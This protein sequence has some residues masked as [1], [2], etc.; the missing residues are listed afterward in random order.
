M[1]EEINVTIIVGTIDWHR[2]RVVKR[3]KQQENDLRQRAAT[4]GVSGQRLLADH[5][6][7]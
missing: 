5:H 2:P 4:G 7:S 3:N 6:E 1:L